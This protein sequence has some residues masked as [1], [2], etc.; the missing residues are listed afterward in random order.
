MT[1]LVIMLLVQ[2]RVVALLIALI[3]MI[4]LASLETCLVTM[5][6]VLFLVAAEDQEVVEAEQQEDSVVAIC[7]LKSN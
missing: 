1:G 5:L 7:V 2:E 6:L 3:W 4:S